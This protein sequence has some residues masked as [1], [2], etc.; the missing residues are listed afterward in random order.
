MHLYKIRRNIGTLM[1]CGL[2]TRPAYKLLV[3]TYVVVCYFVPLVVVLIV[4]LIFPS[5]LTLTG[6]TK[7]LIFSGLTTV[8]VFAGLWVVFRIADKKYF[9]KTPSDLI[10]SR[11]N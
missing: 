3:F 1:A 10:Y 4:Q 8:L 11:T 5:F 6:S 9:Y 2:N 7:A